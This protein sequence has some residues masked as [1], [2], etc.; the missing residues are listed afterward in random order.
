MNWNVTILPMILSGRGGRVITTYKKEDLH[1][2][3]ESG[4]DVWAD[5]EQGDSYGDEEYGGEE[6]G[7]D[8]DN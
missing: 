7:E 5:E 3:L 2:Q 4:E 6:E 8:D 1:T